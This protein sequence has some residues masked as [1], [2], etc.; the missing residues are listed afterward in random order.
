M[1]DLKRHSFP[2]A[3]ARINDFPRRVMKSFIEQKYA[4]DTPT[5]VCFYVIATKL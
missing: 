4:L 1:N 3:H 2:L 5:C